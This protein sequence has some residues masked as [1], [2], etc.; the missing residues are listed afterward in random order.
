LATNAVKYGALRQAGG[1]VRIEWNLAQN[2]FGDR[3]LSLLWTESGGPPVTPPTRTG[4]GSR[5]IGQTFSNQDGGRAKIDFRP[6]GVR[7]TLAVRL[8]DA[9]GAP[10]YADSTTAVI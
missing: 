1:V 3:F 8:V 7:C 9:S 4:F 10:A 5:L 6:E 2:G